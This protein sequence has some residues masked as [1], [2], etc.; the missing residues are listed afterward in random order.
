MSAFPID[1]HTLCMQA[2]NTILMQCRCAASS[3]SS[4]LSYVINTSPVLSQLYEPVHE[5]FN[6]VVSA[7]SKASDQPVHTRSLI[8]AFASGL[9]IL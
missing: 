3:E 8:R 9:S 2:V 6:N 1:F 4:L 5:I 7:T